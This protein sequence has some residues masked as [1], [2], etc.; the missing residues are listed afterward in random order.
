MQY[1]FRKIQGIKGYLKYN[2]S[3]ILWFCM[4]LHKYTDSEKLFGHMG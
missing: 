4:N 2:N 1:D 3:S